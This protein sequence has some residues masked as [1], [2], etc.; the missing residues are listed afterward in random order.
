MKIRKGDNVV[1]LSGKD[2]GKQGKIAKVT[3]FLM[4]V[5]VDGLNL[6]TKHTKPRRQG[7]KGQKI[8]IPRFVPASTV[9]LVCPKCSKPTRVRW[10]IEGETK[11]RVCK[12]CGRAI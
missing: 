4:K 1:M 8:Q 5:V 10:N 9:M 12:K 7:E 3:P 2:R 11:E 6:L